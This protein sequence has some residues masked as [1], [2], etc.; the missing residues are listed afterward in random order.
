[1]A[2]ARQ[3]AEA[4]RSLE[5]AAAEPRPLRHLLAFLDG[6]QGERWRATWP[7]QPGWSSASC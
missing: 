5:D 3:I 6:L 4:G 1:M 7:P 2:E